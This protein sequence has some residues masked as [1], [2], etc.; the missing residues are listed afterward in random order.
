MIALCRG[1]PCR[2]YVLM[3]FLF[4]LQNYVKGQIELVRRISHSRRAITLNSS[5][6]F[7]WSIHEWKSNVKSLQRKQKALTEKDVSFFIFLLQ[8]NFGEV[9]YPIFF[10]FPVSGRSIEEC[11]DQEPHCFCNISH[12]RIT[13][14]F[15][16]VQGM[17]WWENKV[18]SCVVIFF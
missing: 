8:R 7:L 4:D 15:M 13:H 9:W 11:M 10:L 16:I 14:D 1:Q 3:W 18:V 5:R 12:T 2:G 17:I 6:S